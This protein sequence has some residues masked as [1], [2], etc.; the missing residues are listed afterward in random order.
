MLRVASFPYSIPKKIQSLLLGLFIS[1]IALDSVPNLFSLFTYPK[2]VLDPL[3]DVTGLWQS[4]WQ[5]FAPDADKVNT[6]VTAVIAFSN[7]ATAEWSSPD[8][9]K[10]GSKERFLR[11]REGEFYDNIRMD[12]NKGAWESFADHLTRMAADKYR[13]ENPE[14]AA[15]PIRIALFRHWGVVPYPH[16]ASWI[17]YGSFPPINGKYE[18]YKKNYP[19]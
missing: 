17:P 9:T 10:L 11:F 18:F 1:L 19:Q 12:E 4:S 7:G 3:F 15:H 2:K 6:R 14:Q 13:T 5:L 16:E 8:W